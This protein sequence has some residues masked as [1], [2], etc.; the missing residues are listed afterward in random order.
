VESS[1]LIW[2]LLGI[3]LLFERRVNLSLFLSISF[4]CVRIMFP[5]SIKWGG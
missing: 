3:F 4:E 2:R 1:T 5:N